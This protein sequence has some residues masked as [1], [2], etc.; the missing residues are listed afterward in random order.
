MSADLITALS[1]PRIG[2]DE[3][4][5]VGP[6]SAPAGVSWFDATH[7]QL[8]AAARTMVGM[9]TGL[10]LRAGDAI[11]V[12]SRYSEAVQFVPLEM[13]ARHLGVV[14]CHVEGTRFDAHRLTLYFTHLPIKAVIGLTGEVV[15]NLG[16]E[17]RQL[18]SDDTVVIAAAPAAA[19]LRDAGIEALGMANVGPALAVECSARH[20]LH[21]NASVWGISQHDGHIVVD[22]AGEVLDTGLRGVLDTD[23]C[24]CGS[25]EPRF[26]PAAAREVH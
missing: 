26:I 5:I 23:E 1:S 9:L 3:I 15:D 11:A 12:V 6:V 18:L 24:P 19:A 7:R 8:D 17:L 14:T 2:A 22:N 4:A 10:G 21:L 16:V 13:A 20:G 25:A